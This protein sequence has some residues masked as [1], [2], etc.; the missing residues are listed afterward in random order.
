MALAFAESGARVV[1]VDRDG[2][3]SQA[4]QEQLRDNGA[5]IVLR[6]FDLSRVDTITQFIDDLIDEL[7]W[8]DVW[9]NNARSGTRTEPLEESI[10]NWSDTFD[11]V[12]KAPLFASQHLIKRA[13][14]HEKAINILN[15]SSILAATVS[16][17]S[18][19]YHLAK[20]GLESLTRY[21][22]VHGGPFGV[23]ANAIR[24]GFIVQDEHQEMYRSEDNASYRK[25][26][27]NCHPLGQVGSSDD[28]AQSALFLCSDQAKF[29]TGHVLALDGGIQ[30]NE[31]FTLLRTKS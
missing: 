6:E 31:P 30:N 18:A 7:G 8:I 1:V 23:R 2:K 26:A 25:V 16:V 5:Q 13:R 24:P 10:E 28:V 11:V 12:L 15:I 3:N 9:V 27:E 29:I 4:L 20:A 17:E 19:S 22:A 14:E 21:L